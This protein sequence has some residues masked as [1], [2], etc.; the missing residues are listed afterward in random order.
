MFQLEFDLPPGVTVREVFGH[1]HPGAT[2]AAV[3]SHHL[4]ANDANHLIVNLN[5]KAIGKISL[6]LR[7]EQRLS[8]ANLLA[9]TGTAAKR[10]LVVPKAKQEHLSRVTGRLLLATPESLRLNQP[11]SMVCG[12]SP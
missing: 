7:L 2:P 4:D 6:G 9:P 8:D 3:D 5:K 1:D 12:P 10:T 11:L